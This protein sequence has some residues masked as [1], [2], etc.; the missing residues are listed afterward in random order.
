MKRR[1]VITGGS[2]ISALGNEWPAVLEK[3]K[4]GKNCVR[5]MDDWEKYTKMNTKLA[6]PVDFTMPDYPRKKIRGLGRV[7]QMALTSAD[8]ALCDAGIKTDDPLLK[9]G[10]CG[11]SYGSSMGSIDSLMDFY[12][13]LVN[14]DLSRMNATTYIKAMPQTCAANIGVFFGITGRIITTNTACNS[15]AQA[16]GYAYETILHGYQDIMLAGGA[17]ELSAADSAVFD[18]LFVASSKNDNPEKTPAAYDK[19]RDGLVIGEGAGTVILEEYEHAKKRAAKII[20]EV[21]GFGTNSDGTHITQPNRDTMAVAMKLALESSGLDSSVIG[22]VNA[23]GT[24]TDIGDIAETWATADVFQRKVP[25]S[26]IKNYTGH[27]LGACGVIE[28]WISIH[29]MKEKWFCP[30][31][32]LDELD[33]RCGPLDYITGSGR[34]IETEY[35]MSNN[36][37]FGGMNSSLIF[38]NLSE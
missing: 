2:I 18:T 4:S 11:I 34:R 3:L 16:I 29:M 8:R 17:E 38:K 14:N 25:I 5:R 21:A 12:S 10:R 19:N 1:V 31:I 26:T 22:Y 7:A 30:N 37:A 6:A 33:G 15:S 27:T 13:M 35:V 24:A 23:H 9:G 28:A 20:A 36:F 32:N